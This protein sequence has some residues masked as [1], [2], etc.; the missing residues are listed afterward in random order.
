[1]ND[2]QLP[3]SSF[4]D[5]IKKK[6]KEISDY[7]YALDES[8]I[9]AITDAKGIITHVN[10]NFCRISK[11]TAE[12]LIGKDHRIINSGYHPKEFI[13]N[14]WTTIGKGKIWSGDLKNK[15]KDGTIYWVE[16]TIVP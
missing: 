5:E 7:K 9:V 15:A 12:E 13:R 8:S 1:M 3:G 10:D 11:Y 16:T 14:L 2:N 4:L 6:S